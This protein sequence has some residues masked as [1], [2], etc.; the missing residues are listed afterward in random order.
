MLQKIL[1]KTV[2]LCCVLTSHEGLYDISITQL[3]D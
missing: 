2:V 1:E 3:V